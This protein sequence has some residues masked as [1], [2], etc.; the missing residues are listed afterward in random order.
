MQNPIQR[1]HRRQQLVRIDLIDSE[2][3]GING[4]GRRTS[5]VMVP[6][7][8]PPNTSA[9]IGFIWIN[10]WSR[11]T[12]ERTLLSARLSYC[13]ASNVIAP[14][15]VT[16]LNKPDS[17]WGAD[18]EESCVLGADSAAGGL[19]N[20]WKSTTFA[21]SARRVNCTLGAAR[22]LSVR[23]PLRFVCPT[24]TDKLWRAVE[25]AVKV[26]SE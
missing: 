21:L 6:L 11:T 26:M 19:K 15:P 10:P 2:F 24:V 12:V 16:R 9:V 22:S 1:R 7:C 3:H 4:L 23:E 13:I 5:I 14:P 18:S 20:C 25:S 17:P 8:L